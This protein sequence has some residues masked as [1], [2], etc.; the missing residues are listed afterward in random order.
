MNKQ[1]LVG[2]IHELNMGG[3]ER[4]MVNTLNYFGASGTDVHLIIFNNVGVLKESLDSEI[5]LHDLKSKSVKKGVQK[6][7]KE[8]HSIKPDTVFSGIN[9]LN[10]LLAP[11]IPVMR[12]LLPK[13]R[14]V[15]RETNIASLQKQEEKYPKLF[16]WLYKKTYHNYDV[17]IAQAQVMRDDL[18]KHAPKAGRKSVVINNPIDS[19]RIQKLSQ[20]SITF[21]FDSRYIN[22]I[23]VGRLRHTKRHDILLKAF[24]ELPQKC[25]LTIVGEGNEESSLK[26]LASSL[27]IESR[28]AFVGQK[29][30][31]YPYMKK[32]DLLVLTSEH[33]GFPNVL[34]E[35]NSLGVPV[36]AFNC[37][38]GMSEIIEDGLNGFLVPCMNIKSLIDA[39]KKAIKISFD[40]EEIQNSIESRYSEK[41]ILEKYREVFYE[42]L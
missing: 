10:I 27:D 25:R 19:K 30:N 34:L 3:A 21:P 35:A 13:T 29:S 9:H 28:V 22:I 38:G 32:S 8:L 36:I 1:T 16:D 40:I 24:A 41:I 7:L 23:S 31:P 26:L 33:E 12:K 37:P 5:T 18:L 11:F 15:C 17:I 14:W 6:L 39:I 2:I 4:M 42:G 20:E